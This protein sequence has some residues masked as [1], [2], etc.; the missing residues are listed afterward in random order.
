MAL[1]QNVTLPAGGEF[2]FVRAFA[3]SGR[4]A[5]AERLQA[6]G[7]VDRIADLLFAGAQ[8]LSLAQASTGALLN[9][10]FAESGDAFKGEMG[11]GGVVE[12]FGGMANRHAPHNGLA[13]RKGH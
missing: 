8:K 9:A 1:L 5:I 4:N 2:E 12:F 11:F 10:K 3:A 13:I 6:G 7:L